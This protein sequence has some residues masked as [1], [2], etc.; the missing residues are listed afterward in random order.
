MQA[1]LTGHLVFST[2]HTNNA[3]GIIPRLI[4]MGVDPYLIAPTLILGIAQRLVGVLVPEAAE[5]VKVE[6]SIKA[7]IDKQ[8]E[9]LPAQFKKDIPFGDTL[10]RI[11]PTPSAPKGTRG[12]MAVFE[13]F[14]MDKEVE[15]AVL[16]SATETEV[17]KLLRQKG[18][19]TIKEDAIV[20]AFQKIV[21]LEEVN[22]L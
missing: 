12:R 19:M 20:K 21:P 18:M 10:Y 2:L 11:K 6:G 14:A 7:M 22:K 3:A 4:D 17:S 5:P 8:F 13:M 9:D 1:A 15:E 16:R